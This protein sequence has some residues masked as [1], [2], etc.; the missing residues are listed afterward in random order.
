MFPVR[1]EPV[2]PIFRTSTSLFGKRRMAATGAELLSR[3]PAPTRS[4]ARNSR[5]PED[6]APGQER[7]SIH[8]EKFLYASLRAPGILSVRRNRMTWAARQRSHVLLRC[9]VTQGNGIG[10]P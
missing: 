7:S 2:S 8:K 4:P 10:R 1:A 6:Q 5:I 3:S 9:E